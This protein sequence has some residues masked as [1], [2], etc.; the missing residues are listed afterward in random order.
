[1]DSHHVRQDVDP[2]RKHA[3]QALRAARKASIAR[4]TETV[5]RQRREIQAILA[6]LEKSPATVPEIAAATGLLSADVL[7]YVAAFKKYG[8]VAEAE[9][10]EGYYRY[11]SIEAANTSK[12][13]AAEGEPK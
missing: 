13:G 2:G 3:I 12:T 6:F 11:R 8:R 4:T 5:K 1:M 7:W 10:D 9:K